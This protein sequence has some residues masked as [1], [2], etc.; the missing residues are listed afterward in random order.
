MLFESKDDL[1]QQTRMLFSF[2]DVDC[3]GVITAQVYTICY[4]GMRSVIE[5]GRFHDRMCSLTIECVLL[6]QNVFS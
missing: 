1:L 5:C 2:L 4:V 6:R 3:R